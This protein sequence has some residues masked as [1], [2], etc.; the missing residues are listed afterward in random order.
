MLYTI[1]VTRTSIFF[2]MRTWVYIWT[3]YDPSARG[4]ARAPKLISYD[5]RSEGGTIKRQKKVSDFLMVSINSF[6]ATETLVKQVLLEYRYILLCSANG[7][8]FLDLSTLF[9]CIMRNL[10]I[11]ERFYQLYKRILRVLEGLHLQ[12]EVMRLSNKFGNQK[13]ISSIGFLRWMKFH[14]VLRKIK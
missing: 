2:S 12:K 3:G 6:H 8:R 10:F 11:K 4:S 14:A 13:F 1:D 9:M 5:A 7:Q